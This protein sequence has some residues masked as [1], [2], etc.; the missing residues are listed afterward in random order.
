MIPFVYSL[1]NLWIKRITTLLT[2]LGMAFVVLVFASI[3]MLAEGMRQTLIE[4]GSYDNV[5]LLRKGSTTEILSSINRSEAS[6]VATQPEV[7][8]SNDG[9]Y[10]L[11]RELVVLINLPRRGAAKQANVT[12]RGIEEQSLLLRPRVKVVR[13]RPPKPGSSEIMSGRRV[14]ERFQG[15]EIGETIHFGLRDWHVVGVFDAGNTGFSS[16]IWGDGDQLM[17]AFHRQVFSSIT[18]RLSQTSDFPWVKEHIEHNPR[19]TLEAKRESQY[20]L[21]QAEPMAQFLRTLASSMAMIFSLGAIIGAIIT[22][23]SAVANRTREIGTMRALGF[24]K[25]SILAA[26]LTESLLLGLLG[27]FLGLFLASF[28]QS[29]TVSTMNFQTFSELTFTLSL[30]P[31]IIYKTLGFS[32]IMGLAGGLFP[33]LKAARM[34]IVEAL[35]AG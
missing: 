16:E 7:A 3:L 13:G 22:M 18:F 6:I 34:N 28:L 11:A 26:F 23:Y 19:L 1:R 15:G 35:R 20:Y 8:I 31:E 12:I 5:I 2:S 24:Q 4:T 21:E 25:I 30:S 14:A 17:Q 32:L 9:P 27:G 29:L 10:L 33:S